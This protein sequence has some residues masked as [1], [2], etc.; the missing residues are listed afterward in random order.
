LID[1]DM[2]YD[3]LMITIYVLWSRN[4]LCL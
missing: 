2:V 4:Y 1:H 3:D